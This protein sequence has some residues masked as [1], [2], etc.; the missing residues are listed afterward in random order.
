MGSVVRISHSFLV[1]RISKTE[2]YRCP[3]VDDVLARMEREDRK[4][5]D[6]HAN[7]GR[8]RGTKRSLASSSVVDS[9]KKKRQEKLPQE[10]SCTQEVEKIHEDEV[11]QDEIDED[12]M[13]NVESYD[14]R[15][16]SDEELL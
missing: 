6:N 5:D 3:T 7:R 13:D 9:R 4:D 14:N 1:R 15:W 10:E 11:V 2:W 12:I 16:D 8:H